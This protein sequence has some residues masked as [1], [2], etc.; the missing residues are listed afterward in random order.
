MFLQPA[1][2]GA[3]RVLPRRQCLLK[4]AAPLQHLGEVSHRP[5]GRD[6]VQ[7]GAVVGEVQPEVGGR[8]SNLVEGGFQFALALGQVLVHLKHL[9]P[10]VFNLLN[11]GTPGVGLGIHQD[12]VP[13]GALFREILLVDL[14]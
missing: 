14:D 13:L 9:D 1:V 11:R 10:L 2:G 7:E 5:G 12:R 6:V 8:A 3:E 4:A